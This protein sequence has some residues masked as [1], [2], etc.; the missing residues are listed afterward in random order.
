MMPFS[1]GG[2]QFSPLPVQCGQKEVYI[3]AT[4]IT[5]FKAHTYKATYCWCI[6]LPDPVR[7]D[8]MLKLSGL[9]DVSAGK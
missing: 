5:R 6:L 8:K 1:S 9:E 4:E 2:F 3:R 7:Q